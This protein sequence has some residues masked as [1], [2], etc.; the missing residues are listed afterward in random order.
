MGVSVCTHAALTGHAHWLRRLCV[1]AR[2]IPLT[3]IE[4]VVSPARRSY[5][6]TLRLGLR[7]LCARASSSHFDLHTKRSETNAA[8]VRVR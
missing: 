1:S 7:R 2:L 3:T 4:V 6:L 8:R 5:A